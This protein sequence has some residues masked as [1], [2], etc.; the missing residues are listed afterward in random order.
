MDLFDIFNYVYIEYIISIL[1]FTE[2]LKKY[3]AK[4]KSKFWSHPKWLTLAVSIGLGII[5]AK[6]KMTTEEG[7]NYS[8]LF[9]S[10]GVTTIFY[11]YL[12]KIIKDIALSKFQKIEKEVEEKKEEPAKEE[13][14]PEESK[15][16]K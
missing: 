5:E 4:P 7:L 14:K 13:D 16:N 8:K 2:L 6:Y 11:D 15:E 12:I 1:L 3:L 9:I 10:F